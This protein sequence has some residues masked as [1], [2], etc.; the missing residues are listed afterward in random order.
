M[1]LVVTDIEWVMEYNPKQCFKWFEDEVVHDRR[2]ADMRPEY[3]IRGE[4]S[5]T[6]GNVAYGYTLMDKTKH[7]SIRFCTE[8]NI[9]N[10]IRN[11]LFKSLDELNGEV[12]EVEKG[13]RKVIL[14]TPIQIGI[15][16]YSYA[17]LNLLSFWEFINKFLVNDLYQLMECDTDSLYIAF[18]RETID[19]C[20][21]PELKEEWDTEKHNFFSST[22]DSDF[23]FG[24]ENIPFSQW[25]KRTPGK[26]K[27][28]FEGVGMICLNSKVFH[29]W[30]DKLDKEG[31]LIVK[32]SCKGTQKKRNDLIRKN[33]FYVLESCNP[34]FI[35]NAGFI[36]DGLDTKTYTQ[37]K[38][39]LG[40]FYG[41]RK[42]L[43][44]G[45]STTHLDI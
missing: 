35:E 32:T 20:V 13:K 36:R 15:A 39:G 25:D 17:K 29:I 9:D 10:H 7:T 6:K 11:P 30:S 28:E 24:G 37:I 27:P 42:V 33:F 45:V 2:M 12:F 43:A 40:Y 26:Y 14:D 4:T 16:V 1:G 44:D 8:S 23:K 34:Y 38:K 3:K 19:E 41:K 31:M 21:K 22:D 5:K 18:A